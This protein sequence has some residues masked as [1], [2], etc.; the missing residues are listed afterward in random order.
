MRSS[1]RAVR[2]LVKGRVQG[3]G[4]RFFAR[5]KASALGLRGQVRN[6]PNGCVEAVAAG[7]EQAVTEFVAELEAGPSAGYVDSVEVTELQRLTVPACGF[8]IAH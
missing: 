4:Y 6:L 7:T 2:V 1:E 3:V 8:S 5:H